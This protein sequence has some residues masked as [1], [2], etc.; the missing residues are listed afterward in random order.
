MLEGIQIP[1]CPTQLRTVAERLMMMVTK[2][3]Y[4]VGDY[5]S[6]TKL[7]KMLMMD[8]WKEYDRLVEQASERFFLTQEK[9]YIQFRQWFVKYATDP[10]LISRATRWLV[11]HNYLFLDPDVQQRAMLAEQKF[12]NAIRG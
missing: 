6:I 12:S 9:A 11:S 10:D 3:G 7:D 8:Y 2:P 4:T 1:N 5:N